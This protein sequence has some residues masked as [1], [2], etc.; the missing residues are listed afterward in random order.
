MK[1]GNNNYMNDKTDTNQQADITPLA[2]ATVPTGERRTA[3]SQL[4]LLVAMAV[5]SASWLSYQAVSEAIVVNRLLDQVHDAVGQ[6][7]QVNT[8]N[9]LGSNL[10]ETNPR[11]AGL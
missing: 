10:N 2:E 6:V 1:K 9:H 3:S 4:K 8:L 5:L 7:P 11:V